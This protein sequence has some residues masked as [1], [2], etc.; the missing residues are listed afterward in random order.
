MVCA[1][2]CPPQ[3]L[4]SLGAEIYLGTEGKQS[5]TPKDAFW[6]IEYFKL[7]IFKKKASGK[8]FK[9]AIIIDNYSLI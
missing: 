6:G 4:S 7:V 5:F 9:G 2:V 1:L 3:R 8:T